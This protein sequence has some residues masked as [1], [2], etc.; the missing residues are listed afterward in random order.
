MTR[1]SASCASWKWDFQ[2]SQVRSSCSNPS[3]LGRSS[4]KVFSASRERDATAT[5]HASNIARP[6]RLAFRCASSQRVI[7]SGTHRSS[8]HQDNIPCWRPITSITSPTVL[9]SPRWSRRLRR[10]KCLKRVVSFL[11][12]TTHVSSTQERTNFFPTRLAVWVVAWRS[13]L[14][15][16]FSLGV[17]RQNCCRHPKLKGR[18]SQ[19]LRRLG[20]TLGLCLP[21]CSQL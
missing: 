13:S 4:G 20:R 9:V 10:L 2:F 8:N 15:D 19:V 17:G 3:N 7:N 18:R 6:A 21:P 5:S 14:R 12:R 1:S 11:R 16:H